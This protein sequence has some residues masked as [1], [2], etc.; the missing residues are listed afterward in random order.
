VEETSMPSAY[1][2]QPGDNLSLIAKKNGLPSWQAIYN[3][4]DNAGFRAKRPNP[5]L[6]FPG[7]VVMLPDSPPGGGSRVSPP[8]VP[9]SPSSTDPKTVAESV[10]AEPLRWLLSTVSQLEGFRGRLKMGASDFLG[11]DALP[12]EV[13]RVH[14][15]INSPESE[16]VKLNRIIKNYKEMLNVIG[17]QSKTVF[18]NASDAEATAAG[19]ARDGNIFPAWTYNRNFPNGAINLTS[20]FVSLKTPCQQVII[21]HESM[22]FVEPEPGPGL[23]DISEADPAYDDV[24]VLPPDKTIHNPSS[25][26]AGAY[27]LANGTRKRDFC[28]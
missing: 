11:M 15:H 23:P 2:V 21:V 25:Y 20:S 17:T 18:K 22:H 9:A 1:T 19:A 3:S 7:D 6:I 4:P 10:K 12:R 8:A 5:N 24:N 27:H 13:L 26:A 14:F 16:P 28:L